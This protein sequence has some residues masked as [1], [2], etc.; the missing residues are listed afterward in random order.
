MI[1][2]STFTFQKDLESQSLCE[3]TFLSRNVYMSD[4]PTPVLCSFPHSLLGVDA[5]G[6]LCFQWSGRALVAIVLWSRV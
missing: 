4:F 5:L 2:P 3:V 1:S 6:R